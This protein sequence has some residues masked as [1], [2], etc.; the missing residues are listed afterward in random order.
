MGLAIGTVTLWGTVWEHESG[1]R[2]QFGRVHT[3]DM[4]IEEF[5]HRRTEG[6]YLRSLRIRYGCEMQANV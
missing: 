2:A 3:I 1:F 6:A 4:L 5:E